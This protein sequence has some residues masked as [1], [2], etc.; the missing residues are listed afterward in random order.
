ML[1]IKQIGISNKGFVNIDSVSRTVISIYE[2]YSDM[3]CFITLSIPTIVTTSVQVLYLLFHISWGIF[4]NTIVSVITDNE[5]IIKVKKYYSNCLFAWRYETV[6]VQ[7]RLTL[8]RFLKYRKL[9]RERFSS[10]I[11]PIRKLAQNIRIGHIIHELEHSLHQIHLC[12]TELLHDCRSTNS[13]DTKPSFN[14]PLF[15]IYCSKCKSCVSMQELRVGAATV[16]D[17]DPPWHLIEHKTELLYTMYV[18]L[19]ACYKLF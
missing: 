11:C 13:S 6:L 5:N 10:W 1:E 14:Q 3:K 8:G 12:E 18:I 7:V 9:W 2:Y 16:W 17:N 15:I 19:P 4:V